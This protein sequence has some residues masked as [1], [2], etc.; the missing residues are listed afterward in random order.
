MESWSLQMKNQ[1]KL[2]I[3]QGIIRYILNSTH[4]TLKDIAH[5]SNASIQSIRSIYHDHQMPSNFYSSEKQLV[6]LYEMILELKIQEGTHLKNINQDDQHEN[7][8]Y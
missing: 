5:L 4:C 7:T 8:E 2:Q 1:Q 6:Q 3:Y